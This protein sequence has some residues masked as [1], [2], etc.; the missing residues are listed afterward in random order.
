MKHELL[1]LENKWE[2]INKFLFYAIEHNLDKV[3]IPAQTTKNISDFF[4]S[5]LFTAIIS[6]PIGSSEPQIKL[7][8]VILCINRNIKII[9]YTINLFDLENFNI[10]TII[11]E[12]K[13][14]HELCK[15]KKVKLRPVLEYKILSHE[16]LLTLCNA[17]HS[18]GIE[19]LIIGTGYSIDDYQDNMIVSCFIQEKYSMNVVSSAPIVNQS[20]YNKMNKNN[21][22]GVRIKSYRLLDNLCIN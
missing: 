8:E 6:Y 19:E 21:I 17:I 20:Q 14:C 18:L 10:R 7:H 15:S 2:E 16:D 11:S 12:L 1:C 13:S 3:S 4:D 9:D 22:F 5:S